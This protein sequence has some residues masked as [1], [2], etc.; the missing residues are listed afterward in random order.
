MVYPIIPKQ[1][2]HKSETA[3]AMVTPVFSL[4]DLH[5]SRSI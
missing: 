2:N 5:A 4:S 3:G 1:L